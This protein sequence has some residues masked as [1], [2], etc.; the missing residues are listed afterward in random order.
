MQIERDKTAEEISKRYDIWRHKYVR[1]YTGTAPAEK[2]TPR[3]KPHVKG[4]ERDT[5]RKRV[6]YTNGKKVTIFEY[7]YKGSW[8]SLDELSELLS[9]NKQTINYHLNKGRTIA[10]IITRQPK[11]EQY[12]YKGTL[13]SV[14]QLARMA[15]VTINTIHKRLKYQ[16]LTVAEAVERKPRRAGNVK[17]KVEYNGRLYTY[18]EFAGLLGMST[19]WVARQLR[20]M[21]TYEYLAKLGIKEL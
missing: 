13:Y 2:A 4:G 7:L 10:E 20:K 19:D 11:A 12:E 21:T 18:E 16:G 14:E 9:I 8:H 1:T 3:I 5:R 17:K 15:G 6:I